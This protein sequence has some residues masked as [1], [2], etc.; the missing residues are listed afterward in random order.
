METMTASEAEKFTRVSGYTMDEVRF[1]WRYWRD[2]GDIDGFVAYV[3]DRIGG[4]F[5]TSATGINERI[6][7]KTS[8]MQSA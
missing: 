1:A 8:E 6:K 3:R 7:T 5:P 2:A 4:E